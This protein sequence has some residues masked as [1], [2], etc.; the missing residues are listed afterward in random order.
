MVT[1]S[2]GICTSASPVDGFPAEEQPFLRDA[3]DGEDEDGFLVDRIPASLPSW[4]FY[5]TSTPF[6][7]AGLCHFCWPPFLLLLPDHKSVCGW[8]GPKA[9]PAWQRGGAPAMSLEIGLK[10]LPAVRQEGPCTRPAGTLSLRAHL[11][12]YV[13]FW[14]DMVPSFVPIL[15]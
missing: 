1:S 7:P 12:N 15:E 14:R 13:F 5:L 2:S 8:A 6:K 3:Y 9:R 10:D 11:G 4:R